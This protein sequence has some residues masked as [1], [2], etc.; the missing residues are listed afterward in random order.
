MSYGFLTEATQDDHW[1]VGQKV[2]TARFG[3]TALMPNGHGWKKHLPKK[4]IQRRGSLETQACTIFGS[5]NAWETL[6]NFYGFNDFPKDLAERYNAILAN[7]TPEGGYAHVSCETFR[8]FG[9]LPEHLLP[10]S[11]DIRTWDY[12]Y[13]PKP[14]DE[15]LIKLG[16]DL[17]RKFVLG[18]EWIFNNT[19]PVDYAQKLKSAL[20]RGTVAISVYAWEK[21]GKY[22]VSRKPNNHWLQLVDYKEGEYWEMFDHYEPTLKRIAWDAN[23]TS[24]KLYFLKRNE[25]GVIPTELDWLS[26]MLEKIMSM[27]KKLGSWTGL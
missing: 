11:E 2:A 4:E 10:F 13:T 17:L 1:E 20:E 19:Y 7:I 15:N 23:F 26:A 3:A 25:S 18:H 12:F 22:Y 9:A 27:L 6:A 16:Q 5:A 8:K 24:A 14:M 21:D